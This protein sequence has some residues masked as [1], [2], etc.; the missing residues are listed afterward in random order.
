[1]ST[2]I[3]IEYLPTIGEAKSIKTIKQGRKVS[4]TNGFIDESPLNVGTRN[5][6][7]LRLTCNTIMKHPKTSKKQKELAKAIFEKG[8]CNKSEL[9]II[10]S[11]MKRYK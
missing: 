11:I 9:N 8:Y 5:K 3:E 6:F 2:K 10:M 4:I 7:N 1:M